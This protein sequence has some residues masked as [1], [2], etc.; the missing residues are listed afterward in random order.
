M[1]ITAEVVE[2]DL[3][4][5]KVI[6]SL[7]GIVLPATISII[8]IVVNFALTIKNY[9]Y[10]KRQNKKKME[11][12]AVYSYYLPVKFLLLKVH[13]AY[14]SV[15]TKKFSIFNTYKSEINARNER[16]RI[17]C[18]YRLF[19]ENYVKIDKK[20][21]NFEIDQKIEKVYEH[22]LFVEMEG[23]FN[24][25]IQGE[26]YLLPNIQDILSD[27]DKYVQQTLNVDKKREC[28]LFERIRR[29]FGVN[30]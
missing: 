1:L 18:A 10:T 11:I 27:I 28:R 14:M 21:L 23:G 20:L 19:S 16:D 29:R 12:D 4:Q 6:I 3:E 24:K 22:I 9:N 2:I 17:L 26:E 7:L 8:T 13:F 25:N 15:Q 30:I 5:L